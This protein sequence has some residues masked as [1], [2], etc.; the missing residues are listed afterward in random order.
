MKA[1]ATFSFR[2]LF[3]CISR[4]PLVDKEVTIKNNFSSKT[5]VVK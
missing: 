4:V 3:A 5:A 2:L 1:T